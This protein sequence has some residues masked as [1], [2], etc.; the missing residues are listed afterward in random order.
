MASGPT[1]S[2]CCCCCCCCCSSCPAYSPASS[3]LCSAMSAS[4]SSSPLAPP[5]APAAGAPARP[6][7]AAS[8]SAR[9][10]RA[11]ARRSSERLRRA[12]FSTSNSSRVAIFHSSNFSFCSSKSLSVA[13]HGIAGIQYKGGCD[14][15]HK[16]FDRAC[17]RA[18]RFMNISSSSFVSVARLISL[19]LLSSSSRRSWRASISLLRSSSLRCRSRSSALRCAS[20]LRVATSDARNFASSSLNLA[21]VPSSAPNMRRLRFRAP[22][23]APSSPLAPPSPPPSPSGAPRLVPRALP[24]DSGSALA[25]S[26]LTTTEDTSRLRGAGAGGTSMGTSSREPLMGRPPLLKRRPLSL[27]SWS[28]GGRPLRG[29]GGPMTASLPIGGGRDGASLRPLLPAPIIIPPGGPAGSL[30]PIHPP[31]AGPE[32]GPSILERGPTPPI[33]L[34]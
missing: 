3:S 17:L 9:L 33:I 32:P 18:M 13:G 11:A 22:P 25:R 29:G 23:A 28:L 27:S 16:K 24:G 8:R 21:R 6:C 5:A 31:A 34:P 30:M 10:A 7:L 15:V 14:F 19:S 1:C 12:S 26:S 4:S 20:I 2:S